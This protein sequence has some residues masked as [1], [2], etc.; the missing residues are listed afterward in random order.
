MK[1]IDLSHNIHPGIPVYPG[2]EPP[3]FVPASTIEHNGFAET[4]ISI[5]THT[6][7]HMDAPSHVLKN[8]KSLDSFDA[9]HFWGRA[10]IVDASRISKDQITV[11]CLASYEARLEQVDFALIKTGWSRHWGRDDYF[12]GFPSLTVESARWLT[13]FKLKGVAVD[14]ISIDPLDSGSLPVHHVLLGN[15]IVIVE[16]LTRLDA[17]KSEKFYFSCLPLKIS[18]AD[19]SPVRAAAIE[20]FAR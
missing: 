8:G 10:L 2:T 4:R 6:A 7:T 13:R 15:D 12:T 20:G 18:G 9:G 19:G 17:V 14:A 1:V 11:D 3:F 5:Y 16:N